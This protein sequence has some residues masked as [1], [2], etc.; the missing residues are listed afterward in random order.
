MRL[1]ASVNAAGSGVLVTNAAAN[2]YA[3]DVIA[4]E[5]LAAG[6]SD[7]IR[8]VLADL[9]AKG[10]TVTERDIRVK[11]DELLAQAIAQVKPEKK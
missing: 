10:V 7:V 3:K 9:S 1:T 11:M 8:K 6:D 2:S 5:F 4:A